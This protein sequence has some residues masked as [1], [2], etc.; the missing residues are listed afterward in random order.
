MIKKICGEPLDILL[1]EDNM[2]HAEL[3]MRSF[4]QHRVSNCITHVQDGQ[5]ALDYIY[6]QGKYQNAD[7]NL[8]HIVLLDLRLPKV[9][10][11]LLSMFSENETVIF[12]FV[13]TLIAP[14]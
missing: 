14:P 1:V 13:A 9:V 6:R 11:E 5:A 2:A 8:P 4:E 7:V 12:V 10:I 3:I